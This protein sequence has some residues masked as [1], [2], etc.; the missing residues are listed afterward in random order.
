MISAGTAFA[1]ENVDTTAEID[2]IAIKTFGSAH[3]T[4]DKRR[5]GKRR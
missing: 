1:A 2:G 5:S 3:I 4:G